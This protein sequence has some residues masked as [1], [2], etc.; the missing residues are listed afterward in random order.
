MLAYF[1][2]KTQTLQV[3]NL[4]ILR[5]QNE[6]LSGYYFYINLNKWEEFQICI[7]V[8]LM[9]LLKTFADKIYSYLL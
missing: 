6:K 2:R 5:I 8:P 9:L 3:S 7:S 4:R 1:L